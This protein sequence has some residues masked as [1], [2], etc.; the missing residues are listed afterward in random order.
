MTKTFQSNINPALYTRWCIE[1]DSKVFRFTI[2]GTT[3]Q[4][5]ADNFRIL[6]YLLKY[7]HKAAVQ[8]IDRDKMLGLIANQ[9][10]KPDYN[11]ETGSMLASEEL[12]EQIGIG[13]VF[14]IE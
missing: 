14:K 2:A 5:Y 8:E 12:I 13:M 10:V 1:K 9:V 4:G 7:D 3:C 11:T 6:S